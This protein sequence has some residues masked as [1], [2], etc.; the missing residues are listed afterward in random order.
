MIDNVDHVI[1][2]S[3]GVTAAV[4][5]SDDNSELTSSKGSTSCSS[6]CKADGMFILDFQVDTGGDDGIMEVQKMILYDAAGNLPR[7]RSRLWLI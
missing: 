4:S 2:C 6:D 1:H 3:R 5:C 7:I